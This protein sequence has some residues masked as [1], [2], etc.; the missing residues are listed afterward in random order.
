[1][2]PPPW[3]FAPPE[4]WT[5][6]IVRLPSDEALHATKVLRLRRGD[7]ITVMDG[8]G[9]VGRGEVLSAGVDV[10]VRLLSSKAETPPRPRLV[11]YQ[12]EAKGSKLDGL[13]ER[14]A[15][16]GVAELWS[17]ASERSIVRW[18]EVKTARLDRRW[19]QIAR[20]AAK[21]SRNP[22]LLE[23]HAGLGWHDL[24]AKVER[25]PFALTLWEEASLP[26]RAALESTS[27]RI[28]LIVGPEGGLTR[29]EAESLADAGAPLVSL[30]PRVFRTEDAAV[31]AAAGLLFHLGLIG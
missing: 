22:F 1:M 27:D 21:Q 20:S 12:G 13:V 23:P 6:E 18:D 16:L 15:E 9:T 19:S 2:F 28:A 25:E 5:G 26:M 17:Y 30:G 11:V 7:E 3:F 10:R 31:V 4:A 29:D 8:A 24:V 14:L